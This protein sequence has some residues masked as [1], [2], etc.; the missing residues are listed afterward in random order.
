MKVAGLIGTDGGISF[1][2]EGFYSALSRVGHNTG[3]TLFQRAM[4][5]LVQ[6]PKM[7]AGPGVVEPDHLRRVADVLVLPAANQINPNFNLDSWSDYID[8][9]DLPCVVI[10]LGAQADDINLTPSELVLTE[11]VQRFANSIATRSNIIG[12]RGEF[13]RTV[14]ATLGIN[15]TV[16][17]GCPSQT[18]NPNVTGAQISDI[19]HRVRSKNDL[20]VALLGGTLQE[21]T[22][23][24]ERIL[25]GVVRPYRNHICI[26]QTEPRV[27]RFLHERFVDDASKSFIDWMKDVV[28]PDMRLD[29]FFYYLA[30]HGRVYS[31]AR[32][33]IDAMRRVDVAIGMRI[34]GAVAAI[35]AGRLGV[36][37][38]FD[39]R[40][41]ELAKTMGVPYILSQDI[42]EGHSLLDLLDLVH[43]DPH[44]FEEKRQRNVTA[45]HDIL[46]EI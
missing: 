34:H 29:Q 32:S 35:Q 17:T 7:L 18:I 6:G 40:T 16:V 4:W 9:A 23:N 10:G 31:D 5:N 38:A 46:S 39:S 22:R 26:Y 44:E 36:C 43:F 8:K 11:S 3:N 33:W 25:Y 27:L 30:I 37:V 42:E 41:L 21:F 12:V 24:V 20:T 19:L 2:A 13:T 15:N 1:A 28:R 14:L 45:I